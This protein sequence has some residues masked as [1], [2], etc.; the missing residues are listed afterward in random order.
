MKIKS[1]LVLRN[2]L[3]NLLGLNT[4]DRVLSKDYIFI[5]KAVIEAGDL[6]EE[7]NKTRKEYAN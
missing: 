3:R 6:R 1:K 4:L 2:R 5:K 7:L